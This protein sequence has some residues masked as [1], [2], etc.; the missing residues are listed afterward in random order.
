MLPLL[1][2]ALPDHRYNGSRTLAR[3]AG[4]PGRT[5]FAQWYPTAFLVA[6]KDDKKGASLFITYSNIFHVT[7]PVTPGATFPPGFLF[8]LPHFPELFIF[9]RVSVNAVSVALWS[10]LRSM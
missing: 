2:G 6:N 3:H 9:C 8:I 7:S 4:S 1:L 10:S 5:R